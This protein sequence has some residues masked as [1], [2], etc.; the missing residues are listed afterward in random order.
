M[1]SI[2]FITPSINRPT[3][4]Q[5]CDS[6][7]P[8]LGPDDEHLVIFDSA[9]VLP[10]DERNAPIHRQRTC[11]SFAEPGSIVGNAQRDFALGLAQG[12]FAVFIDDDDIVLPEAIEVLRTADPTKV[13]AFSMAYANGDVVLP[14]VE[15]CKIGGPQVVWPLTQSPLPRWTLRNLYAS[16]FDCIEFLALHHSPFVLHSEIICAV[17]PNG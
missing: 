17:R 8:L 5:C 10:D 9:H 13:H 6:I 11:F 1:N 15:L 2:T 16:D 4:R 7:T 14:L 3:L 12:T